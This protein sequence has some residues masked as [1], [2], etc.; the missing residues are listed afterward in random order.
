MLPRLA[1]ALDPV[2]RIPRTHL[3]AKGVAGIGRI[4]DEPP[5]SKDFSDLSYQT[6]LRVDGM[7]FDQIRH[8]GILNTLAGQP[9][10]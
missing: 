4:N 8:P 2:H 1:D 6:E 10:S 9:A 7:D 5:R 3:A